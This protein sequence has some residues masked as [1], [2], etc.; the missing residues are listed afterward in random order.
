[1]LSLSTSRAVWQLRSKKGLDKL[2]D[3]NIVFGFLIIFFE[4][5]AYLHIYTGWS[6]GD[7]VFFK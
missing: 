1:M 7:K 2:L 6:D 3:L 5:Q 4:K